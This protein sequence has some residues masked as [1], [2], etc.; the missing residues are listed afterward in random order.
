M[1]GRGLNQVDSTSR[2][3]NRS[4]GDPHNLWATMH[5]HPTPTRRK[6][7]SP[8]LVKML[9]L[10]ERDSRDSFLSTNRELKL[11]D[12]QPSRNL[13]TMLNALVSRQEWYEVLLP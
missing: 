1:P 4:L 7:N 5:S 6:G 13:R 8:L 11:S 2:L 9:F 3:L 12:S 10:K